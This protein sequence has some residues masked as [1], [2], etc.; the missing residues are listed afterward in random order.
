MDRWYYCL[1]FLLL[2]Q[3]TED[4]FISI[5]SR[6]WRFSLFVLFC[7]LLPRR[8]ITWLN[9]W[10]YRTVKLIECNI[11][12]L[13]QVASYTTKTLHRLKLHSR[14]YLV[15]LH[16]I[17]S[18]FHV[19]KAIRIISVFILRIAVTRSDCSITASALMNIIYNRCYKIVTI[20]MY[21]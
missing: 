7:F 18:P 13:Y 8:N 2:L 12:L 5:N 20:R 4:S 17:L 11:Y 21:I 19:V 1:S 6:V 14:N 9:A 15:V 16:M 3:L 10:R